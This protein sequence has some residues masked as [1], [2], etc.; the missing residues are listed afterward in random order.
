M[1]ITPRPKQTHSVLVRPLNEKIIARLRIVVEMPF[2][3]H[4]PA[5]APAA[6]A[7][8]ALCVMRLLSAAGLTARGLFAGCKTHCRSVK[9][10]ECKAHSRH[11]TRKS[12]CKLE[13]RTMKLLCALLVTFR[14]CI[15]LPMR[16]QPT[17]VHHVVAVRRH[18]RYDFICCLT[19]VSFKYIV[20]VTSISLYVLI[21]YY[22]TIY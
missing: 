22:C 5:A 10:S 16:V 4:S 6:S 20:D 14:R 3:L 9:S 8:D 2:S 15:R 12:C 21:N 17:R 11:L 1:K 19:N 7:A 13:R 18:V